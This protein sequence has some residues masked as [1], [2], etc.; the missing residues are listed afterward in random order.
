M[1]TKSRKHIGVLLLGVE[2]TGNVAIRKC[3]NVRKIKLT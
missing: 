3:G 2:Q 1:R